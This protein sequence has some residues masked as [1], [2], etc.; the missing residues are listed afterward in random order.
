MIIIWHDKFIF[1]SQII[2]YFEKLDN[3]VCCCKEL[4]ESRSNA[5]ETL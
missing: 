5:D 2:R 4:C 3:F 1:C